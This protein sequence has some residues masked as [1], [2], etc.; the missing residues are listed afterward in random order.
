MQANAGMVNKGSCHCGKVHFEAH[1]E[2]AFAVQC[3]CSVCRRCHSASYAPLVG[4]APDKL[5]ISKGAENLVKY[6]TGREDR[7]SCK[8][9][10]SKVYSELNHLKHRA[11]F[12]PNFSWG[13]ADSKGYPAKF[14]PSCHIFYSSGTVSVYD[15]LPKYDNLPKAFGGDDKTH[16]DDYHDKRSPK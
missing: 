1:G 15:G 14:K 9:C 8:T 2:P 6:V 11:V 3:H 10:G 13:G 12:T 4:F 7:F 16:A 5:K